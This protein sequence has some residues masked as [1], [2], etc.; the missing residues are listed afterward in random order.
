MPTSATGTWNS[1]TLRQRGFTLLEILVVVLIIG[2]MVA[3]T[4]LSVGLAH[5][6]R[7]LN[8][9]R[10]RILGL[11]DYMREQA[12]LQ[13]REFGIRCFDG[14]YEFLVNSID[15]ASG[16]IIWQR[17]PDDRLMRSRKLPQ[18]IELQLAVD[19]RPVKLPEEEVPDDELSPQV[20]LFSTGEM[21]LFQ[22]TLRRGPQ[23]AGVRIEPSQAED[24]VESTPVA[25]GAI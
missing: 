11:T 14:G 24:R 4:V 6:D 19:G 25:A 8:N 3:G 21:T 10:D 9:E 15:L 17:V 18:G 13:G 23:G 7:E 20:L 22:L 2:I 16:S 12:S 5:G 1:P